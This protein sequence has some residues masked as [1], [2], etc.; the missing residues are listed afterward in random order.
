MSHLGGDS[1]HRNAPESA[2]LAVKLAV[3]HFSGLIKSQPTLS[4]IFGLGQQETA[5]TVFLTVSDNRPRNGRD[6]AL[7]SHCRKRE[8]L[9]RP[10]CGN[11][12]DWRDNRCD[13]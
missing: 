3:T 2:G 1:V 7:R 11:Y 8:Y 9:G 6:G 13:N 10:G 12:P 5:L 4:P